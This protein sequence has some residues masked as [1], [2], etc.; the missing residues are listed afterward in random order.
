MVRRIPVAK[1]TATRFQT[2][3]PTAKSLLGTSRKSAMTN[4][5][6]GISPPAEHNIHARVFGARKQAAV[7]LTSV[8]VAA[9]YPT[10]NVLACCAK[11]IAMQCVHRLWPPGVRPPIGPHRCHFRVSPSASFFL[12]NFVIGVIGKRG[13]GLDRGEPRHCDDGNQRRAGGRP[14]HGC[15]WDAMGRQRSYT[16]VGGAGC[17]GVGWGVVG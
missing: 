13:V 2:R 8:P 15:F 9:C 3:R 17:C 14:A 4:A 5:T 6:A 11:D 7:R 10:K 1:T 16:F 12:E